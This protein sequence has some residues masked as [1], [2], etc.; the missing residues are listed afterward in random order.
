MAYTGNTD[1]WEAGLQYKKNEDKEYME[2][3]AY[4]Q[5]AFQNQTGD[6]R[7]GE[8]IRQRLHKPS[9]RASN[10]FQWLRKSDEDKG[11]RLQSFLGY[12]AIPQRLTVTPGPFASMLNDGQAYASFRQEAR[13]NSLNFNNTFTLLSPFRIGNISFHPQLS[14]AAEKTHVSSDMYA[15]ENVPPLEADSLKNRLD[16]MRYT[17]GAGIGIE[18][19]GSKLRVSL[20]LPVN[21]MRLDTRNRDVSEHYNRFYFQPSLTFKYPLG[22]QTD[23]N[24]TYYFTHQ[25]GDIY[26]GYTGYIMQDYRLLNR[27]DGR[28]L[29]SAIQQGDLGVRYK[30][31]PSMFFMNAG[32]RYNHIK[33][34]MLYKQQFEGINAFVSSVKQ[35]NSMA[36]FSLDGGLGKGFYWMNL[37]LSLDVAY[38]LLSSEQL[39]QEQLL[40]YN[41]RSLNLTGRISGKPASWLLFNYQGVWGENRT[42]IEG[43]E[44]FRPLHIFVNQISFDV[45]LPQDISL[46]M[47]HERYYNS[48]LTENRKLSFTDLSVKYSLRKML[49]SL[50]WENIFN[51]KNYLSA[52]NDGIN[53]NLHRY[54]IRGSYVLFKVQFKLK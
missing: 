39:R 25:T 5:G 36:L 17:G 1:L 52:Y 47:A 33:R 12:N 23:L 50:A 13:I 7:M 48:Y 27:Y 18:Y 37:L 32:I 31:I 20:S 16:W 4:V 51:T 19:Q 14:A 26:S 34:N 49:L 42:Q 40:R 46:N 9:F 28:L 15:G 43:E 29:E 8:Q 45:L 10:H 11:F 41:N 44:P 54:A 2:N 35:P 24:G 21:F 3:T 6:V 22:S 53:S 30:D 38:S